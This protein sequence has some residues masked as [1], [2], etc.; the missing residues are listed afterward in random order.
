MTSTR[1]YFIAWLAMSIL[2]GN[3]ARAVDVIVVCPDEFREALKPWL[4]HRRAEDLEIQVIASDRD[5]ERLQRSIRAASDHD[6]TYVML[7]GDAPVIGKAGDPARQVP[8]IYAP[9]TVTAA[10]GSTATLASDSPFGDF[11]GDKVPDAVVGRL[12]VDRPVQLQRLIGR[13]LA[14]EKSVDFGAWRGNVQ[15]TG[16]I[17]GFGVM[18]D[19]AIESVTRTVVTNVLPTETRTSVAY[20]SPGHA[21]YPAGDSFTDAVLNRY[22]QGSRFWVYAGHGQ[23]TAL[24]R[25]PQSR[26][27]IPVLDSS[28]VKRLKCPVGAA[29]IAMML[30]CYTGA[31]DAA[32][33]SL[34]EQM[35]L[36]DGGPIA[37]FAGSRV[38][39]PY[40]NTTAAVGL[41]DGVYNQKLPRLGDAWLNTLT[42][43]HVED[44][45]EQSTSRMMI[46][47]LAAVV[48][49]RGTK[50]VDER[51]EHMLLYNLI[52][53]P[54]LCLHHPQP[55]S[56]EVAAGHELGEP[57]RIDVTSP[58]AGELTVSLDR[59]LG[60]V[61]EGNP[62]ETTVASLTSSIVPGRMTSPMITLPAEVIGP[63]VVRA[64]VSGDRVWATAA[65]RTIVR[66]GATK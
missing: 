62:N 27:G 21:F 60:A 36:C 9:T 48:S 47:A 6:T 37:V 41:I 42:Q 33:D 65:A 16:G 35:L 38:T 61:T 55:M 13:I 57:I 22:Q 2:A 3:V 52:G 43:M 32:E 15:L 26:Y 66:S 20:A 53:D 4:E 59:P 50:L 34:S 64:I 7:V 46:D 51:R 44:P 28:S 29:P 39:M 18:A 30:A 40:G 56:L 24:D 19:A 54:T 14:H 58:I 23:V 25:V 31:I 17:G 49:P 63:I 8:V 5:A 45:A 10:W 11:D 12:P 1:F